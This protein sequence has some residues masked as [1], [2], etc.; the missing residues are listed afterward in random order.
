MAVANALFLYWYKASKFFKFF[1]VLVIWFI[2]ENTTFCKCQ[3]SR[4]K[5][6]YIYIFIVLLMSIV[7]TEIVFPFIPDIDNSLWLLSFFVSLNIN[8]IYCHLYIDIYLFT[9]FYFYSF[10]F[11]FFTIYIQ[12]H[13]LFL[14][15][16]LYLHLDHDFLARKLICWTSL[17]QF[18]LC[19]L[20]RI[21]QNQ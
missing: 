14:I 10:H 4:H 20:V 12:F 8:F 17:K 3:I 11:F 5:L 15:V 19:T 9:F 2:Q 1:L 18:T 16:P 21:F 13:L 6:V 7:A